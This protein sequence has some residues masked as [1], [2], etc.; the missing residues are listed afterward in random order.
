MIKGICL[1]RRAIGL[2]LVLLLFAGAAQA[3]FL[4]AHTAG[5]FG[6]NAATQPD[7]G[8]Y[9]SA[10]Y[11]GYDGDSIRDKNGNVIEYPGGGGDL[12][13]N[14]YALGW[15]HVSEAKLWGGNYSFMI[16]P[17]VTDNKLEIPVLGQSQ[18]VSTG[19]TDLYVQPINLGWHTDRID[20]SAGLGLYLPTGSYTAG[21]DDNRGLGMWTVEVSGGA[22]VWLDEAKTWSFSTLAFFETHSEKE[23]TDVR[24]GNILT[25]EGGLGKAFMGGLVN[26]GVAYYAQWKVSDDDLGD[27]VPPG[28]L[29]FVGKN[30]GYGI[31]PDV[32]LPLMSKSKLYGTVNARYLWE[33]GVQSSV[34]GQMLWLTFTFMVPPLALN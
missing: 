14:A 19:L 1:A 29:N 15:W 13:V 32:T 25:V 24:V 9:V 20:Y 18:K 10:L 26:L 3:Q 31:G 22:T 28:D 6:V 33:S 16:W 34:E 23:D 11:F 5:D 12:T 21:A 17:A 30:S 4:G 2:G 27:F 8:D 7:P